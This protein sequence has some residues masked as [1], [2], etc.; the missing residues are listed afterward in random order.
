[1]VAKLLPCFPD[2]GKCAPEYIAA[3]VYSFSLYSEGVQTRMASVEH[4]LASKHSY[5]PAVADARA[6]GDEFKHLEYGAEGNN[7]PPVWIWEGTPA[8]YAWQK[9]RPFGTPSIDK[10]NEETGKYEKGWYFA[11]NWPPPSKKNISS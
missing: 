7:S 4:G 6:M 9:L 5:I 2:Y 10:M 11:T 8:W 3:M 1:M